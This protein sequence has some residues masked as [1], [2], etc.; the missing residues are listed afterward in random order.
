MA[1]YWENSCS[2]G[3]RYVSWYK[4]LIV[5]LVFSHLSFWSGNLFLIAPFP[6]LCLLVP[7]CVGLIRKSRFFFISCEGSIL[8]PGIYVAATTVV[9]GVATLITV[10]IL[11]IHHRTDDPPPVGTA[12]YT[13]SRGVGKLCRLD[14]INN[15]VTKVEPADVVDTEGR[16]QTVATQD[17]PLSW[18]RI[19]LIWDKS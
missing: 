7:F 6:D 19:A 16:K 4:Y 15:S 5:S 9:A 11:Y 14:A 13:L 1:T 10:W 2:F 3:L 8:F 18:E 17:E 12:L